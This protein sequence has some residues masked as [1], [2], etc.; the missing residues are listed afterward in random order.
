[1][2]YIFDAWYAALPDT[3]CPQRAAVGQYLCDL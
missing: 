3:P 1:M 2:A